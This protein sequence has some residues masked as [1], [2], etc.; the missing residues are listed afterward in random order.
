M[1][2]TKICGEEEIK[3]LVILDS[4]SPPPHITFTD[5]IKYTY[6]TPTKLPFASTNL[7]NFRVAVYLF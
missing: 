4:N 5:S 3:K 7:F 2:F 1:Q 6:V